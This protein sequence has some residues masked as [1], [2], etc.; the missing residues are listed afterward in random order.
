VR[1]AAILFATLLVA[2]AADAGVAA[3]EEAVTIPAADPAD[4]CVVLLHGLWRT[5]LSMLAVEWTL[6]RSGYQVANVGYP[7]LTQTIEQNAQAAVSEGLADC[8]ETGRP[9]ISFVTHSLGGI[10]VRDYL[11][12]R[13]VPELARVVMMGPPNQGSEMA[14]Y[15]AELIA[16]DY[17][18]PP[19]LK[20]LGTGPASVPLAL[21]PVAFELGVIAGSEH[22]REFLPGLPDDPGDGTV[23]LRETVIAGM[24]DFI[25]LP[26]S[27]T[28]MMWDSE[29]LDQILH[30]LRY[31]RFD[32]TR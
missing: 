23:S 11:H 4:E 18:R 7:S 12:D 10:L 8:R 29:V 27:H 24:A 2:L 22:R 1:P 30:F 6:S 19:A 17:L 26:T 25:A 21:G 15:Y 5:P 9:R 14:D 13:D 20:Q 16:I 32:H 3:A 28:M 31:G